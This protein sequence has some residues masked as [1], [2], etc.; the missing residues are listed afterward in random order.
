[1]TLLAKSRTSPKKVSQFF[2]SLRNHSYL[3][4]TKQIPQEKS[5]ERH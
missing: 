2:D 5:I 4:E 1:M 3:C